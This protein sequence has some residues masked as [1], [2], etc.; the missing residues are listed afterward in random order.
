MITHDWPTPYVHQIMRHLR[1]V[2][3][4]NTR[5]V[6]VEFVIPY[7][8]CATGGLSHIP[9]ADV[10]PVPEPLIPNLITNW[11]ATN[12]SLQVCERLLS[13]NEC[14]TRAMVD[15]DDDRFKLSGAHVWGFHRFGYSF[16]ME[17]GQS[18]PRAARL[19]FTAG[20]YSRM[21]A[22]ERVMNA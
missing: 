7:A 1:D 19:S 16:R 17:T 4:P 18:S 21:I 11:Y 12:L 9:G 22:I 20:I 14:L 10:D 6:I 3:V 13:K 15:A 5:L 8:G 2:A